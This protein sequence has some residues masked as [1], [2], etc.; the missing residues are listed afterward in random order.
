MRKSSR[1]F[2]NFSF[3]F[4]ISSDNDG[5]GLKNFAGDGVELIEDTKLGIEL[6][7][8]NNTLFFPVNSNFNFMIFFFY[9][10]REIQN[11]S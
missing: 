2:S 6:E 7:K 5:I 9:K 8:K 3:G 4:R 11:D 1:A 10:F